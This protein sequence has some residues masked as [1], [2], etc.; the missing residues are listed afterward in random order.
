PGLSRQQLAGAG[1][2]P[3][4]DLVTPLVVDGLEVVDVERGKRDRAVLSPG[5][6]ELERRALV[7]AA[8]VEQPGERVYSGLCCQLGEQRLVAMNERQGDPGHHA[9]ADHDVHPAS[10]VAA[11][12]R[13]REERGGVSHAHARDYRHRSPSTKEERHPQHGPHVQDGTVAGTG[14]GGERVSDERYAERSQWREPSSRKPRAEGQE[15]QSDR[16]RD[17]DGRDREARIARKKAI[18]PAVEGCRSVDRASRVGHEPPV[19]AET[20]ERGT[21]LTGI[22]CQRDKHHT[23]SQDSAFLVPG[24]SGRSRR[25]EQPRAV[26][27]HLPEAIL[28]SAM[29]SEV[30]VDPGERDWRLEAEL[31]TPAPGGVLR[32]LI[33]RLRGDEDL[34]EQ[35]ES[36]LSRDVVVTHDGHLLFAY[37]ATQQALGAARQAVGDRAEDSVET[38]TMV[39]SSGR[40]VR[41]EFEQTMREWASKLGLQCEVI[42]HAHLLSTQVGFT[43]TGPRRK[44][45]EF[46]QGL[47]AEGWAMVRTESAVML[48][49]L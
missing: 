36:E 29:A 38:R 31:D 15:S 30:P 28:P 4:A 22:G 47:R 27:R 37:A 16:E 10:R 12:C 18:D 44:I 19:Q 23:C 45:D 2:D 20:D 24:G 34:A 48:S 5:V 49:P 43:V 35:I 25:V 39:A 14:S 41:A 42:E 9:H 26:Q 32:D 13:Q 40:L 8:S 7:E 17:E 3:V 11:G 6:R 1:E 21:H 46:A 33:G